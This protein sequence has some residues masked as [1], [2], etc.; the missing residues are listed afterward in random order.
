MGL[1]F[2]KVEGEI[3]AVM[4]KYKPSDEDGNISLKTSY[5]LWKATRKSEPKPNPSVAEKK[6]V[7]A[8]T[9]SSEP[10]KP[11]KLWTSTDFRGRGIH[12]L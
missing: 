7:A 11:D 2:D 10:E 9:S 3:S 1:T 5:D 8:I 4:T 12:D 6:K